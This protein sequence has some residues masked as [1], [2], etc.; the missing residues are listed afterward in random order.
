VDDEVAII[1]AQGDE[2]I[3]ADELAELAGTISW[4]ILAG[5]THRVPRLYLR[6]GAVVAHSTLNEPLAAEEIAVSA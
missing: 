1:G 6:D 4:E 3:D 2:R 5:I